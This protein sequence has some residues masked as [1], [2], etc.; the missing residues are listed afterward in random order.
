VTPNA[1]QSL[2]APVDMPARTKQNREGSQYGGSPRVRSR[3][4]V[5]LVVFLGLWMVGAEQY[6]FCP[7]IAIAASQ[8][9][10]KS[11]L[12]RLD[13]MEI[14][15]AVILVLSIDAMLWTSHISD[16]IRSADVW[17]SALLLSAVYRSCTSQG[18][19]YIIRCLLGV[20]LLSIGIYLVSEVAPSISTLIE[21]H[22]VPITSHVSVGFSTQNTIF[23]HTVDRPI[24]FLLYANELT[25]FGL[26]IVAVRVHEL[27]IRKWL[28]AT[29]VGLSLLFLILSTSRTIILA[30]L[31]V[32]VILL[33]SRV[34]LAGSSRVLRAMSALTITLTILFVA[35]AAYPNLLSG[36]YSDR[37]ALLT[38]RYGASY[39]LRDESYTVGL[40]IA[41]ANLWTGVGGLPELGEIQAGSHSLPLSIWVE[42]GIPGLIILTTFLLILA[43]RGMY[44]L[45]SG[46]ASLAWLGG[47][48]VIAVL[49]CFTIQFDDDAFCLA[50]VVLAAVV[51]GQRR[52]EELAR[53]ADRRR[54]ASPANKRRVSCNQG[55]RAS[56]PEHKGGSLGFI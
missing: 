9:G 6:I 47:T 44:G 50:G 7:L 37:N 36:L 1:L 16:A 21:S 45:F 42:F 10:A 43:F 30:L 40:K 32:A 33:F 52:R 24:G 26:L 15:A 2:A 8:M 29:Y 19:E 3:V 34:R 31:G 46:S 53:H 27:P 56:V 12:R 48:L 22:R 55:S 25:L 18:R 35:L 13:A 23:S 17:F 39:Q 28:G 5:S 4:V 14:T 49:S 54:K 20:W 11:G 41:Q 51:I 38:A